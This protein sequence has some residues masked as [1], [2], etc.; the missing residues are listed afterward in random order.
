MRARVRHCSCPPGCCTVVDSERREFRRCSARA[1]SV[2]HAATWEVVP[3]VGTDGA[4]APTRLAVGCWFRREEGSCRGDAAN[5]DDSHD[6]HNGD[7]GDTRTASWTTHV[8]GQHLGR[9][10]LYTSDAADEEDSVD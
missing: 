1:R 4:V 9:C 10:L 7:G 3:E 5:G 2:A 6:S 8:V